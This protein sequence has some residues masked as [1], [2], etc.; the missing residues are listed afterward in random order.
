MEALVGGA[1]GPVSCALYPSSS[2]AVDWTTP[3][4]TQRRSIE[5]IDVGTEPGLGDVYATLTQESAI[6]GTSMDL[7]FTPLGRA[8]VR[9]GATGLFA[10]LIGVPQ[11]HVFRGDAA[12]NPVSRQRNVLVLPTGIARL[13]L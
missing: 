7:C 4:T 6:A 8:Y 10:P 12:G 1:S 2:C 5:T 11:L 13:Q 9:Y 3:G